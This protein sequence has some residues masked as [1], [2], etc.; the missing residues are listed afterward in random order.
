MVAVALDRAHRRNNR[1]LA[2]NHRNEP[3]SAFIQTA[4]LRAEN[5]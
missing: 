5:V 2:E 4:K 3:R 1:A